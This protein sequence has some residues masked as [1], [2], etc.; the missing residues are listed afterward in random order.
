MRTSKHHKKIASTKKLWKENAYQRLNQE[1][2]YINIGLPQDEASQKFLGKENQN[3]KEMPLYKILK[4]M[5]HG[6]TT[7][8]TENWSEPV[9][10]TVDQALLNFAEKDWKK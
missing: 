9:V 6:S 4:K 5:L 2:R 8:K 3:I 10:Q 1:L 7:P